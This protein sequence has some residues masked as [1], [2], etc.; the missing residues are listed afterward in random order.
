MKKNY[1]KITVREQPYVYWH[2]ETRDEHYSLLTHQL[3]LSPAGNQSNRIVLEFAPGTYTQRE[4]LGTLGVVLPESTVT[5]GDSYKTL[6]ALAVYYDVDHLYAARARRDEQ[7]VIID[8][9]KPKAVAEIIA[10]LLDTSRFSAAS[11]ETLILDG[12]QLLGKIGYTDFV[13]LVS[14]GW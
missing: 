10:H 8:W 4:T 7:D 2:S 1:R 13:P 11:R 14:W 3:F 6:P 5:D 12:W 9:G